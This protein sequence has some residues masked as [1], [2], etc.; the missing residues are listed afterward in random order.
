VRATGLLWNNLQID[1]HV[2][3][4][5]QI[6]NINNNN[7]VFH[8]TPP[9]RLIHMTYDT[10]L[11]LFEILA[12]SN[13]LLTVFD[14]EWT[15]W[16]NP[17]S[18]MHGAGDPK[19]PTWLKNG[20][21][22]LNEGPYKATWLPQPVNCAAF[23]IAYKMI[24]NPTLNP[25]IVL[26]KA[27]TIQGDLNWGENVTF[28]QI[29]ESI[30]SFPE[31]RF[32]IIF[33]PW[34]NHIQYTVAGSQF[35]Y[36]QSTAHTPTPACSKKLVYF[37][38]DHKSKHYGGC[39]SPLA[40][41]KESHA[42]RRWCHKCVFLFEPR[43][44]CNCTNSVKK[45]KIKVCPFCFKVD[46]RAS[47]CFRTCRNCSAIFKGG[48]D[49]L[50]GEGHRCVVWE[51]PK[52]QTF[53][54]TENPKKPMLW[55]YDFE[56]AITRIEDEYTLD[57]V[58]DETGFI[59]DEGLVRTTTVHPAKHNVNL[60]VFQNVYNEN[61]R[62][63]YFGENAL[64][65]FIR[66]MT[67][68]NNGNNICIAHNGSGYDTRLIF[69]QVISMN[70]P[71]KLEPI[72]RGTK[73]MQLQVNGTTVFKDSLLF[74]PASLSSLAKSF[75]LPMRKGV[76]PHLF[77]SSENF[78]YVG[79]LPDKSMF[80][81]TFCAKSQK[82]IDEF[83]KWYDERIKT[84]WNFKE[85]LI[86]YCQDDVK[87]L[88]LLVKKFNDICVGKF[89]ISPWFSTT[90]PSYVHKVVTSIL[91][92]G[93]MDLLPEHDETLARS[94]A[95]S[96]LARND[97]WAVLLPNEYWFVRK[98][99]RGGRTDARRLQYTLSQ[100][101]IDA[102][103]RIV[104]VDVVS[105]YP[106]V[107]VKYDYPVGL[108]TIHIYDR[109]HFPCN[110]H[111]NPQFGN[112]FDLCACDY[113]LKRLIVSTQLNIVDLVDTQP[114]LE[115]LEDEKTFGFICA[116]LT[117]PKNLFHP[118]LVTWDEARQK[119]IASLDPIKEETFTTVE[120]KVALAMGYKLDKVHRL[121]IYNYKEGLWN[122]FIKDLY[123]EKLANSGP[124]PPEESRDEIER[125]YEESFGMGQQVRD[126]FDRWKKDGALRT[127]FK[128]L[129]NCGWGKHC[130]RPSLPKLTVMNFDNFDAGFFENLDRETIK[131]KNITNLGNTALVSTVDNGLK[132]NPNFHK[133]YLPAG[134]FVP[135][136]GR[137][138]LYRQMMHLEDR[139]LY[140]DT[141]SIIYIY[142]PAKYNIPESPLWGDWDEESISK[143]GITAF[144]SLGPKSYGIRAPGEDI[145]KLKG[146]SI[147]HAH[148]NLVTFDLL[149]SQIDGL[150]KTTL[151]PQMNFIYKPGKGMKT[152]KSLKK[153]E[154]N[155]E[156]LKGFL[157]PDFKVF[158]LGYCVD[159]AW[160]RPHDCE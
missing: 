9:V 114:T 137:L 160:G 65:L 112:T 135:S 29:L 146:L 18:L 61:M 138:V 58:C 134:V 67:S 151:V 154:F 34:F 73:F 76:F 69:E 24:R 35:V 100:E 60:I 86:K 71:H 106:A 54:P 13:E 41:L 83:H 92:E 133:T 139:V 157:G 141:D 12:Q 113:N 2:R 36:H 99:L 4:T 125:Q 128:T 52:V 11:L 109:T 30:E 25:Q 43:Q 148:R 39:Q 124:P 37:V 132:T 19:L 110:K 111:Q 38:Y 14:V 147:K 115:F 104:Y 42:G 150:T 144:V 101:D 131:L 143:K 129:L 145:L 63:T 45:P 122:D 87:I 57:F 120:F 62:F 47:E 75:E 117:P 74:L 17:A 10:F 5:L 126:S 93:I 66:D 159:C 68:I 149:K 49:A 81:L 50:A 46:C 158:P 48:Y 130:Q 53:S 80:D 88:A 79:R 64:E 20:N 32:T 96:E 72:A 51:E 123:I 16:I 140:H 152:T 40:V 1:Q 23:V 15:Y 136:Y 44:G 97:H 33:P 7:Q 91:T 90:A 105:L 102:G 95:I 3:G 142:D 108:P 84:E 55:V 82:D 21:S 127:V 155:P 28:T 119:C 59:L 153:L 156:F 94:Q 70:L 107:Q 78:D 56:S 85:E 8:P 77:N 103:R 6:I 26:E 118:V 89:Q 98:A 22:L 31:Y 116:S 27:R 121:D